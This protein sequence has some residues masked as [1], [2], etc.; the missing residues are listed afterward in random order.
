MQ[1]APGAKF[2][3]GYVRPLISRIAFD[4]VSLIRAASAFVLGDR[5]VQPSFSRSPHATFQPDALRDHY[6]EALIEV[7]EKK[8]AHEP[9]RKSADRPSAAR[10][11]V[12]LMDAL[13]KSVANDTGKPAKAKKHAAGQGEMLMSISGA[14]KGKA[15]AKAPVEKPAARRKAS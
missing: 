9:L 12:N 14:G 5:R 7:I 13:R 6:E 8:Q 3:F 10:N 1:G 15:A 2:E 4:Y 11:V